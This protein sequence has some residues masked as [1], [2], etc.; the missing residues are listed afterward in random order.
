MNLIGNGVVEPLRHV[1]AH[2]VRRRHA[3]DLVAVRL[4]ERRVVSRAALV[5]LH[6]LVEALLVEVTDVEKL[7]VGGDGLRGVRV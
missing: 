7:V 1:S 2:E 5:S 6:E 3:L 4:P